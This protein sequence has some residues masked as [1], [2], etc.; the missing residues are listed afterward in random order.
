MLEGQ[1]AC[2]GPSVGTVVSHHLA[3]SMCL[4]NFI[5]L[6]SDEGYFPMGQILDGRGFNT[7]DCGLQ[8]HNIQ[9]MPGPH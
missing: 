2:N 7:S 1:K 4:P 5:K 9:S 8:L 6:A 3:R